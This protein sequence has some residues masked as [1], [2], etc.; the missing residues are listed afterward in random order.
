MLVTVT[1]SLLPPNNLNWELPGTITSSKTIAV[2]M[3]SIIMPVPNKD[4]LLETLNNLT[5]LLER[6]CQ[7]LPAGVVGNR[8]YAVFSPLLMGPQS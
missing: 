7:L 8:Q 6:I 3:M 1:V 4:G 2:M 5:L